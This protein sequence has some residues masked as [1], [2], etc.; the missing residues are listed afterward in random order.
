MCGSIYL[1][2][3]SA[4]SYSTRRLLI[5]T[6]LSPTA[7]VHYIQDLRV[8]VQYGNPGTGSCILKTETTGIS[9]VLCIVLYIIY[10]I[11]MRYR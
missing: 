2:V 5:S 11:L 7:P 4:C 10:Y 8:S 3:Y 1:F 9:A 6:K